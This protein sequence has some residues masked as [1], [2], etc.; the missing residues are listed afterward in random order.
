MANFENLYISP[1]QGLSTSS[2]GMWGTPSPSCWTPPFACC[3]SC[4]LLGVQL[5]PPQQPQLP[6]PLPLH[7]ALPALHHTCS[8]SSTSISTRSEDASFLSLSLPPLILLLNLLLMRRTETEGHPRHLSTDR[9]RRKRPLYVYTG[10]K[11]T[12]PLYQLQRGSN[13]PCILPNLRQTNSVRFLENYTLAG[14]PLCL[15]I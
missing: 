2:C 5:C 6:Q 12:Y 1:M 3:F 10:C 7:P 13:V 4:T 11:R 15:L 8:N 14:M 9:E